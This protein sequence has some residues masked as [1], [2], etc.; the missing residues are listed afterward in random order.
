[1]KNLKKV[2]VVD[3]KRRSSQKFEGMIE[4]KWGKDYEM[5]VKRSSRQV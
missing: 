2:Q 5:E 4:R 1:M 3:R